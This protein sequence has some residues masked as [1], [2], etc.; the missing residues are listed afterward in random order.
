M[1]G[2]Y[3]NAVM[4]PVALKTVILQDE[5]GNEMATGVIVG[6]KTV[7]T[8]TDNDVRNGIVYAGDEGVSTGSKDIPAYR[9]TQGVTVIKPGEGFSISLP[10]YTGYDYTKLQC[11][12]SKLNSTTEQSVAVDRVAI[13]DS[14]YAVNSTVKLASVIKNSETKSIDLNITNDTSDTYVLRYFTYRLEE[15]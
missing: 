2:L 10:E 6:E 12:I 9:T 8:A 13:D 11:M 1:S 3:G 4:A 14:V 5:S 7:F 15:V